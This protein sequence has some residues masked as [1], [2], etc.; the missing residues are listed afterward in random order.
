MVDADG[1]QLGVVETKEALQKA[2][3]AGFDLVEVAPNSSPPVCRIMDYGKFIYQMKKKEKEAR[4]NQKTAAVKEVKFS[5]KI[6]EHDYEIKLNHARGFLEKGHKVKATMFLR[7]REI[8]RA[9]HGIALMKRL[10]TDLEEYGNPEKS[11]NLDGKIISLM[12]APKSGKN[13][14]SKGK[15]KQNGDKI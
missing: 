8:T 5:V 4:K 3:D 12:F 15:V 2:E 14:S 9:D 1:G 10:G 13:P 11:P 7:G 6:G